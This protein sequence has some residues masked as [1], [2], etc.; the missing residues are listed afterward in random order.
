MITTKIKPARRALASPEAKTISSVACAGVSE[1]RVDPIEPR[2]TRSIGGFLFSPAIDLFFIANV[3]WPLLLLVD[4]LGGI[5]THQSLLFWQIY[6]ITAPHRWITLVLVTVDHHKG[7]DRRRHFVAWGTAILVACACVKM[8]TGSLLC[9]GLIDYV[10]NAWHFASQH[11]GIFRIYSRNP[12]ASQATDSSHRTRPGRFSN[13]GQAIEKALFRGFML[14]VVA[15][16]AGWGWTEGPFDGFQWVPMIDWFVLAIPV[17]FLARQ[18]WLCLIT[19][20]ASIASL[21]YLASVM[22]LFASLLMASHYENSQWVV[23]LALASAIFHSLEYMSIVTW[24]MSR[25]RSDGQSNALIRLSQMWLLFLII[26]VI[27]IGLG[28]YLV[29]RGYF[30]LWVFANIVVAFWHYCFDGMIWKSRKTSSSA[31]PSPL[32]SS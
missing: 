30:D 20:R 5:T 32:T 18:C 8:G 4:H 6:F 2:P 13:R 23:Q 22:T 28:N 19:R 25:N 27:V 11:H 10:W 12:S 7:T 16:V 1:I 14:Y 9:L 29:S 26:F 17:T 24:S 3:F 15:R 31:S 21:A